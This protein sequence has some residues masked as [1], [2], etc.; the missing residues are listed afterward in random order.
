MRFFS[1]FFLTLY[2]N[3][4]EIRLIVITYAIYVLNKLLYW[5]SSDYKINKYELEL[6]CYNM[7]FSN[8]KVAVKEIKEI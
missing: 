3:V 8:I 4:I 7:T 6:Y 2:I 5:N 1:R